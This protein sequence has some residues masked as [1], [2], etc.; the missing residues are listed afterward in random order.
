M[1]SSPML[2]AVSVQRTPL[3]DMVILEPRV[4]ADERGYFLEGYNERDMAEAG[5]RQRFVQDNHSY[6]V[7]NVIRGLHYQLRYPQGKLVRVVEGEILDVAVDLRLS[8][9]TFGQ[10]HAVTLSGQ[11]RRILWVPPGF[12]HGF[13][14]LSLCAHVLYKATD[15][16]NPECERTILWNDPNLNIDWRLDHAP[17]VSQKDSA[18]HLFLQAEKFD[19]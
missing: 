6:S 5:I 19:E 18:G 14:V 9:S 17:I 2:A 12:A 16:Y 15:F 4:F 3:S 10:W 11:N 8:S 7:K 1:P 13:R